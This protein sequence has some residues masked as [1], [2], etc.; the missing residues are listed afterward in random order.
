MMDRWKYT[1]E[2]VKVNTTGLETGPPFTP[3]TTLILVHK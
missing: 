2:H 1:V 3:H